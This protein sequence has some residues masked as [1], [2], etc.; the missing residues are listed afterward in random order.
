MINYVQGDL[1]TY[2]GNLAHCVSQDL[3]MGKGIAVTF[4]KKFGNVD[5]LKSQEKQ[6]G[7]VAA[8]R[9]GTQY[10]FYLITKIKYSDKPGYK[11][12]CKSLIAMRNICV[13]NNLTELAMPLIGC[14]LDGL[15]WPRV[16]AMVNE[17]FADVRISIYIY[18]QPADWPAI[19]GVKLMD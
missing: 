14:G 9:W 2:T 6:V 13:A 11:D 10:I 4:K 1:F 5:L 12:L 16:E 7:E 18:V 19:Q 3:V 17:V 15:D 8:I